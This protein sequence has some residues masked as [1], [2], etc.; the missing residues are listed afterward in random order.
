MLTAALPLPL[1]PLPTRQQLLFLQPV[2][3][4]YNLGYSANSTVTDSIKVNLWAPSHLGNSNPDFSVKTLIHT[5]GT[6]S[7]TFNAS[8]VGNSY[9]VAVVHRNSIETWSHNPVTIAT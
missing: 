8:I 6:A 7:A 5:D 4:L 1:L 9:Y 3:N 2:A